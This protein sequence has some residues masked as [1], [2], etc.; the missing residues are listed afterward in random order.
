MSVAT[1]IFCTYIFVL[2]LSPP[3]R[4]DFILLRRFQ[5]IETFLHP[6]NPSENDDGWL[7]P[8]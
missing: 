4:S 8:G 2:N 6:A 5:I 7:L 3:K 1:H